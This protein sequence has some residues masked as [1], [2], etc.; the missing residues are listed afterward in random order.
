MESDRYLD[1]G[2]RASTLDALGAVTVWF[3]LK[4]S[5]DQGTAFDVRAELSVNGTL[6]SSG[7]L[8]CI[9]GVTRTQSQAKQIAVAFSAFAPT[10]VAPTDAIQLKLLTRIGTNADGTKC[11]G[12]ASATGLRAYFD[13]TGRPAAFSEATG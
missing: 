10:T 13:S 6:I 9:T 8:L 1:S 7:T 5:D 3:G 12:H 4:N 2:G 11:S